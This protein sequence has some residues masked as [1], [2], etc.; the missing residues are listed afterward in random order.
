M[1]L[2]EQIESQKLKHEQEIA[3]LEQ[4]QRDEI[5]KTKQGVQQREGQLLMRANE[6]K[7]RAEMLDEQLH[8][9]REEVVF[10]NA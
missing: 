8:K 3:E 7:L 2:E 10:L 5:E 1:L 6:Y 4:V 9:I